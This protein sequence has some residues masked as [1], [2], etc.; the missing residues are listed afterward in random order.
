MTQLLYELKYVQPKKHNVAEIHSIQRSNPSQESAGFF[1]SLFWNTTLWWNISELWFIYLHKV[2]G[3]PIF[4]SVKDSSTTLPTETLS[5][6]DC[7][8]THAEFQHDM[9]M[10]KLVQP[11]VC[12]GDNFPKSKS[13]ISLAKYT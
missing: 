9:W 8:W 6:K 7:S 12:Q 3:S 10:G 4:D 2:L 1:N 13:H 5:V 11:K